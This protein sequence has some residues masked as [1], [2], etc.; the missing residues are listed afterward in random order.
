MPCASLV[1]WKYSQ[2]VA[3]F[4]LFFIFFYFPLNVEVSVLGQQTWHEWSTRSQVLC[5]WYGCND[6]CL[7]MYFLWVKHMQPILD[8][9][10]ICWLLQPAPTGSS[11]QVFTHGK[12]SL[13]F[14]VSFILLAESWAKR[15]GCS[16][17]G[18]V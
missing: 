1:E 15:T 11:S 13:R 14:M 8:S 4:L 3:F 10:V 9:P 5:F 16:A 7:F 18:M 2:Y 17:W 6:C 12:T